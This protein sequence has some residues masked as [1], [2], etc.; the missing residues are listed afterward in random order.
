VTVRDPFSDSADTASWQVPGTTKTL[1]EKLVPGNFTSEERLLT[2]VERTLTDFPAKLRRELYVEL[3]AGRDSLGLLENLKDESFRLTPGAYQLISTRVGK[4][5]A[6][7][8]EPIM[9]HLD[10][11]DRKAAGV[12]RTLLS[13]TGIV[14]PEQRYSGS[15]YAAYTY[16]TR[17]A[18]SSSPSFYDSGITRQTTELA[19]GDLEG[20][21]KLVS[22]VQSDPML[23]KIVM[24]DGQAFGSYLKMS[25]QSLLEA[26]ADY[27]TAPEAYGA[28]IAQFLKRSWTDQIKLTTSID[29]YFGDRKFT[30]SEGAAWIREG[31]TVVDQAF[32]DLTPATLHRPGSRE[33]TGEWGIVA[34][35]RSENSYS[36]NPFVAAAAIAEN[37]E[38]GNKRLEIAGSG[39][40]VGE[41]TVT[42][43][44][45]WYQTREAL[46]NGKRSFDAE[47][48]PPRLS[49]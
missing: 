26:V 43:S 19:K 7:C 13:N 11:T 15:S 44:S 12:L 16:T 9:S 6:S 34:E 36:S 5:L 25:Y 2:L 29:A 31:R 39:V 3:A 27:Q 46:S 4:G 14:I 30:S 32:L 37:S 24:P 17:S 18:G 23:S 48:R 1:L 10:S 45:F 42:A 49:W 8:F 22:Y 41:K 33:W 40:T 35:V 47:G 28:R 38:I 21:S 20:V